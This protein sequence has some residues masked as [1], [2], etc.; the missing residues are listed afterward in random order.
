[1]QQI[2]LWSCHNGLEGINSINAAE[3]ESPGLS[4]W[5]IR[6][7][8]GSGLWVETAQLGQDTGSGAI[9]HLETGCPRILLITHPEVNF[10]LWL[11]EI[12]NYTGKLFISV[13][14]VF[15]NV[16]YKWDLLITTSQ[17]PAAWLRHIKVAVH[18]FSHF[19]LSSWIFYPVSIMLIA[20]AMQLIIKLLSVI[21]LNFSVAGWNLSDQH[22]LSC[23][24]NYFLFGGPTLQQGLFALITQPLFNSH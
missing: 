20:I 15:R 8:C 21:A 10:R 2:S 1:M 9:R 14:P 11:S 22:V 18:L 5:Q 19:W 16:L 6:P 7:E 17:T 24:L 3:N 23:R 4:V 13:L 12:I